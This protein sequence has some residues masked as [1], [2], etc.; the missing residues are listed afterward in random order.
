MRQFT[1]GLASSTRFSNQPFSPHA[2]ISYSASI[3]PSAAIAQALGGGKISP[4]ESREFFVADSARSPGQ[5]D[6]TH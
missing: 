5:P 3:N 6:P 1:P 2:E 4:T